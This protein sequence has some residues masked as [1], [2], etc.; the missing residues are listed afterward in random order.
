MR[1]HHSSTLLKI[2]LFIGFIILTLL[3][4]SSVPIVFYGFQHYLSIIGSLILIPL[5]LVPA[6]GGNY[7]IHLLPLMTLFFSF[8][9]L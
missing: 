3:L 8:N 6:M 1:I 5:V 4:L 9:S 2:D 7:V